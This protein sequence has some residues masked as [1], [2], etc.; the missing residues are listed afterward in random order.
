MKSMLFLA[1]VL[2]SFTGVAQSEELLN[3]SDN[4]I[5]CVHFS[6]S[7]ATITYGNGKSEEVDHM[8]SKEAKQ[9][10]FDDRTESSEALVLNKLI[11]SGWKLN[12]V[13]MGGSTMELKP[14]Y[15]YFVR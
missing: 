8:T 5:V 13:V 2:L 15:F 7:K 10:G 14:A 11:K 6:S 1:I 9:K 3:D 12:S 4:H